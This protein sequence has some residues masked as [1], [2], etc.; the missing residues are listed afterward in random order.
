MIRTFRLRS[1]DLSERLNRVMNIDL[2]LGNAQEERKHAPGKFDNLSKLMY[3]NI[4]VDLGAFK[5]SF[6]KNPRQKMIAL[7]ISSCLD[8]S[9]HLKSI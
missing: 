7:T 5:Q 3:R 6:Y 8:L 1:Q 4:F 2:G 9:R